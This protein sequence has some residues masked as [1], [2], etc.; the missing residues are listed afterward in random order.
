MEMD[1]ENFQKKLYFVNEQLNE[2]HSKLT[3]DI[4]S[5]IPLE[6]LSMMGEFKFSL[7]TGL[8]VN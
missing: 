1:S 6:N 4:Q 5:R 2:L 8:N 3:Y 7:F